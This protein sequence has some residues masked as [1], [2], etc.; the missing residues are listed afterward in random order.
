M[1]VQMPQVDGYAALAMLR[2]DEETSG[3]PVI[4]VTGNAVSDDRK[5]MLDSGFDDIVIKP[6][7]IDDLLNVIN[8][9]LKT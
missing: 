1:D 6:F 9:I 8:R 2:D 3:I 5:R 7:H 4:A